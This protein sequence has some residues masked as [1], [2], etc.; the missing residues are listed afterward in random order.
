MSFPI[1]II[2]S[3]STIDSAYNASNQP[4]TFPT[5]VAAGSVILISQACRDNGI[6]NMTLTDNQGNAYFHIPNSLIQAQDGSSESMGWL[7][8]VAQSTGSLTITANKFGSNFG[9]SIIAYELAH[10]DPAILDSLAATS[11]G[12]SDALSVTSNSGFYTN[13][14]VF[15]SIITLHSG[16]VADLA[17]SGPFNPSIELNS[18]GAFYQH[19]TAS[20]ATTTTDAVT[21]T[22]TSSTSLPRWQISTITLRGYTTKPT[23]LSISTPTPQRGSSV[24][25]YGANF[26]ATG[27]VKFNG[28]NQTITSYTSGAVD[29]TV[30]RGTNKY[31]AP[32]SIV[33]SPD[34]DIDTQPFAGI[35]GMLPQT[36]WKHVDLETLVAPEFRITATGDLASTNQLAWDSVSDKVAIFKDGSFRAHPSVIEF[37]AEGWDGVWG[38]VGAQTLITDTVIN[39]NPGVILIEPFKATVSIGHTLNLNEA[40]TVG[41]TL[42]S[43][44]L[45]NCDGVISDILIQSDEID[46]AKFQSL[47][48]TGHAPGFT[49]FKD[50]I[51]GDYTYEFALFRA[52]LKSVTSDR[53]RLTTTVIQADVPDVF[54]RGS[55]TID[56][57]H[58]SSGVRVDF[59]RPFHVPPEVTMNVKGGTTVCFPRIVGAVDTLGFTAIMTDANNTH[60]AGS[61]TWAAHGF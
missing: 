10:V 15:A 59:T 24:T 50:F 52:R 61:F 41:E 3:I 22:W 40:V 53:A 28:V 33:V 17:V 39:A 55:A 49:P 7:Y 47:V 35:T 13:D 56:S 46:L 48:D 44:I 43:E 58:L 34:G 45:H 8:A 14:L 20:F 60:V 38:A 19:Q 18:A 2:Q 1:S 57:G 54:D 31:G 4:V 27:V 51:P 32:L 36:G 29:V 30:V 11:H 25:V 23:V 26:G 5:S 37:D 42:S 6:N 21:A 16:Y 12:V 9:A